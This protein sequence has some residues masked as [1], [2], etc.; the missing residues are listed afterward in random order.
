MVALSRYII[1]S[2]KHQ[3]E[4]PTFAK[5]WASN[6]GAVRKVDEFTGMLLT[7]AVC[8]RTAVCPACLSVCDD[9]VLWPNGWMDQHATWYGGRPLPR[10]HCVRWG[11]NSLPTK[12]AQQPLLFGPCLLWP[13]GWMSQDATWYAG[14]PQPRLHCVRWGRNS[15]QRGIAAMAYAYSG[16]RQNGSR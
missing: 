14:R 9:S 13:N 6:A 3:S 11:P 4:I 5:T 7:V 1:I 8:Y 16:K 10:P 15:P 12:G 2:T